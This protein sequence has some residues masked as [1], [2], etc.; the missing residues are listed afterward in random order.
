MKEKQMKQSSK[1]CGM[2]D[3]VQQITT[4]QTPVTTYVIGKNWLWVVD[5]MRLRSP[6]VTLAAGESPHELIYP[7]HRADAIN[8]MEW[9]MDQWS[10]WIGG[11]L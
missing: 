11:D 3:P 10:S 7:C 1:V 9:D 4:Y 2:Y 8:R 5:G 6:A